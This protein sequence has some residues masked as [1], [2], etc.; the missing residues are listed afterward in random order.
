M[1]SLAPEVRLSMRSLRIIWIAVFIT[2]AVTGFLLY[3]WRALSHDSPASLAGS[4]WIVFGIPFW[5]AFAAYFAVFTFS[6]Y[7]RPRS[8]YRYVGLTVLSFAG[9][10]FCWLFYMFFAANTYGT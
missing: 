7:L 3:R 4:D 6:P 9:A 10:F 1:A 5:L 2:H 8:V